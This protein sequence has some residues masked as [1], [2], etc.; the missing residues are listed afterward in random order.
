MGLLDDALNLA[1]HGVEVFPVGLDKSPR[2]PH[3]FKDAT[4][5]PETIASW[6]WDD[7]L[8]A[9]SIA[10][11]ELVVDVDP[12][13]GGDA[14]MA[15]LV[16]AHGTLPRTSR[17]KTRSGGDHFYFTIP[18][19]LDLRGTLG[20]GID[21]K[22]PGKGYVVVPPSEG[23][24]WVSAAPMA[25]APAWLIDE[26]RL[27]VRRDEASEPKFWGQFE[28]GTLY[29]LRALDSAIENVREGRGSRHET[30]NREAFGLAQ[31][32]AGGEVDETTAI[33]AMFEA[34]EYR[35]I[36]PK[37]AASVIEGAWAAGLRE[38]RQAP[39][40]NGSTE[41]LRSGDS[42]PTSPAPVDNP[43]VVAEVAERNLWVDWNIDEAEPPFI[44]HP[45][46]P[47]NA[48]VLVYGPTEA[49]KSMTWMG[50][51]AEGS[52]REVR[53][54]VYSLENPPALDRDRLRRWGPDP[55][56]FRLTNEPLDLY[57]SAQVMNL[58]QR[59][60]EWETNVI[61][62]DTYS[63]AFQSRSDDG[64][65]KA[66]EF[67]RRVRFVMA[68]VGCSVVVVDHTGFEGDEPRDASAKRQQVDVAILMRKEG[69]WA[70]GA[71]AKFTMLNRKAARFGNPFRIAGAIHDKRDEAR[72]L[73]LVWNGGEKIDWRLG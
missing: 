7:V 37:R 16:N 58:I 28:K 22:R 8:I 5:D 48:Y 71:D 45:I 39:D 17:V 49:A 29:G 35:D 26:L 47:Y 30:L 57:D 9:A 2:T 10:P 66:I 14:T 12:R 23:Y 50:L 69:E 67:A 70:K 27:D 43:E 55:A 60:K 20:P 24:E 40:E 51:L 25:E 31:L 11:G 32:V 33:T 21:V 65:A 13:N 54:S 56:N 41:G 61:M 59:E 44:C 62:I 73:E 63:H 53:S 4:T 19:G 38:P 6:S 52:L 64:N 36:D 15:A 34:A 3:G 46:L 72:G 18:E 68:E 42:I 1:A